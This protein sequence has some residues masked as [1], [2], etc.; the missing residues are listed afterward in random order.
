MKDLRALEAIKHVSPWLIEYAEAEVFPR[1]HGVDPA[2]DE[3]HIR[4]VL[5][6]SLALSCDYE[7]NV[8]MVYCIAVFHDVGIIHGREDHEKTSAKALLEDEF[9]AERF[10]EEERRIMAEAIEDHR[11]SGKRPPRSIYGC[12][13]A[14]SDR[15]LNPDRIVER[16]VSFALSNNPEADEDRI[17]EIALQHLEEKYGENG[18]LKLYLNDPR[19]VAGLSSIR[20][21][22]REGTMEAKVRKSYKNQCGSKSK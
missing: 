16:C 9:I 8:D 13:V 11:A 5:E 1:Y 2:H 12:I 10:S 21:D 3:R 18:Y 4:T 17:T 22:L 20:K 6:N 7:V 15:D 19:N 14:E